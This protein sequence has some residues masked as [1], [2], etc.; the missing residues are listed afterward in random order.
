MTLIK[1]RAKTYA[2]TFGA[3]HMVDL[4]NFKNDFTLYIIFT[5][6]FL[7]DRLSAIRLLYTVENI[8]KNNF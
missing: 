2:S 5:S 8:L 1:T 6:K 7:L 4:Q 3:T